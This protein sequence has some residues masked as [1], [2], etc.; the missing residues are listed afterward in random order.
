MYYFAI[1]IAIISTISYH[2]L[3]RSISDTTIN[4]FVL[5]LFI[6]LVSII[7]TL[8]VIISFSELSIKNITGIQDKWKY[9]LI[10]VSIVGVELGYILA[11]RSGWKVNITAVFANIS[12][13]ILI[14]P[15]GY[16]LFNES[17]SNIKIF[18][19]G[20]CIIGLFIINA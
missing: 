6:Y 3:I 10:G 2:I 20:L 17:I 7:L 8:I 5:L 19:I 13:A 15:I 16:Y 18:G 9:L 1:S 14:I 12:V 4:P 11:Y